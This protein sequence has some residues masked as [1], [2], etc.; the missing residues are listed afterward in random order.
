MKKNQIISGLILFLFLSTIFNPIFLVYSIR[1]D[2]YQGNIWIKEIQDTNKDKIDDELN[3]KIK[4]TTSNYLDVVL[5]YDSSIKKVDLNR[6]RGLDVKILSGSWD[7]GRRIHVSTSKE[8]LKK[9]TSLPGLSHI[10]SSEKRLIMVAIEGAD[11]TDLEKLTKFK[12]V[13]IFWNVGCAL[14]PYFSG[15][16]NDIKN[17]GTYNAIIDSTNIYYQTTTIPDISDNYEIN[18]ITN[19]NTINASSLWNLG[20]NG[21]GIK[22]GNI[23]TGINHL[24]VDL[25]GRINASQSFVLTIYG[26]DEDDL[27]TTDPNGHGTHTSCRKWNR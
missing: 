18:T 17:L 21:T 7:L 10:T 26:Y 9:I 11:F 3:D 22:V 14:I 8:I 6:L 4:F 24:H 16:E 20:Y 1:G 15:I 27:T 12:G 19:A 13:E 25:A 23:D 2:T 5:Q